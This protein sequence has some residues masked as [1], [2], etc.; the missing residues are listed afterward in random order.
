M[1]ISELL[2]EAAGKC[3]PPNYS[4]LAARLGVEP[5]AV[6]NWRHGRALPD[7]VA[8]AKLAKITGKKPL[9]V[10]AAVNEQRE[11]SEAAKAV[12]RRIGAA[13]VIVLA[14]GFTALPAQ[15]TAGLNS[16]QAMHYA[17]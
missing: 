8:C 16:W 14:T 12:W 4:A 5:S 17:K 6:S 13:A 3:D 10:V 9:L 7:T 1:R 15:A 2:A 11:H